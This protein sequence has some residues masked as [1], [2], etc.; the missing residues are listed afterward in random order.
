MEL[1]S[2]TLQ[3]LSFPQHPIQGFPSLTSRTH[4]Q[5]EPHEKRI[6]GKGEHH[7][8]ALDHT[9]LEERAPLTLFCNFNLPAAELCLL[10]VLHTEIAAAFGVLLLLVAGGGLII[11]AVC[12]GGSWRKK[13]RSEAQHDIP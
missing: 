8:T 5:I 4:R 13:R 9:E 12:V 7:K 10:Y 2:I 3:L 11:R 1:H 6:W